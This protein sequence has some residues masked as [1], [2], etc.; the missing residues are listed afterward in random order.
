MSQDAHKD[1]TSIE[2]WE[3]AV[4]EASAHVEQRGAAAQ[5][6]AERQKP[7]AEGPRIAATVVAL[8]AV[9]A[10]N[11]FVW[12]RPLEPAP[13]PVERVNLAWLVADVADEVE[14]FRAEEGRL[15]TEE[16][17]AALVADDD[18]TYR[19]RG[20]GFEITGTGDGATVRYDGSIPVTEWVAVH[21]TGPEGAGEES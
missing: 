14:D 3:S 18:V 7:K 21:A 9:I 11:G 1:E 6:A 15:P 20:E 17:M 2:G 13:V 8:V 16:E 12:T 4:A 19:R 10:W 5:A